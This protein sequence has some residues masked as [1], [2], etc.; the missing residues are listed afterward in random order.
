MRCVGG[1]GGGPLRFK[2][3]H[4]QRSGLP[5][6]RL[7]TPPSAERFRSLVS[8]EASFGSDVLP[9]KTTE[10][11]AILIG[12]CRSR[13]TAFIIDVHQPL[14]LHKSKVPIA[15]PQEPAL[16]AGVD[17]PPSRGNGGSY[18]ARN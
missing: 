16:K 14:A 2:H 1:I 11:L 7:Q 10:R 3:S 9:E 5:A 13:S 6:A 15:N 18:G 17:R 8:Q 4:S 12:D